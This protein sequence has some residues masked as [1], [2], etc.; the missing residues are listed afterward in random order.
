[1][2]SYTVFIPQRYYTLVGDMFAHISIPPI[3]NIPCMTSNYS[4]RQFLLGYFSQRSSAREE[5]VAREVKISAH[6]E[7]V[8][9][10]HISV[11]KREDAVDEREDQVSA[12]SDQVDQLERAVDAQKQERE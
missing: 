7:E 11:K 9:Q 5:L 6:A 3:L 2:N 12:W 8:E 10:H 4:T 1:M